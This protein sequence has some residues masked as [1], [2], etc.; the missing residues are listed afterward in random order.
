MKAYIIIG[1]HTDLRKYDFADSY[2]V[3]IE[4][5]AAEAIKSGINVDLAVGDF[6]SVSPA[7]AEMIEKRAKKVITL[8]PVKDTTDT[9]DAY[10]R[11]EKYEQIIILGGIAGQR[12]EH[13]YA[14]LLILEKDPKVVLK[15]DFTMITH[16]QSKVKT[17]TI[18]KD[19]RQYRYY[20]FFAIDKATITLKGFRYPLD[21]YAL[22][23]N[24]PLC[25]SNE[26][27]GK[28]DGV[29]TIDG[30]DVVMIESKDDSK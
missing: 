1:R 8:D 23:H 25:I 10:K 28:E 7:E 16:L 5:G 15:D 21:S 9:Y 27:N 6:D 26:L 24:D 2:V 11:L 12:I 19:S 14:N 22:D 4:K 17:Y 18:P 20:S 29:I 30:G 3:G 13:F